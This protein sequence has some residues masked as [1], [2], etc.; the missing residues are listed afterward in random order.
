ME[1]HILNHKMKQKDILYL[2]I[3][4][5]LLTFAWIA[6]NIYHNSINST[7]PEATTIQILPIKSSFDIQTIN[8]LKERQS[9]LPVFEL[10]ISPTPG[11]A[12]Q[13]ATI[14]EAPTPTITEAVIITPT[15]SIIEPVTPSPSE[16]TP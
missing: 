13:S 11:P 4:A 14:E 3:P 5:C 16:I 1:R 7:I 8:A 10:R 2:L 12:T 9:T 15:P 6:F